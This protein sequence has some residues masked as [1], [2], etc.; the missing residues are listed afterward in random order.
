MK[1]EKVI[2]A[3]MRAQRA[4]EKYEADCEKAREQG[5]AS[6]NWN[7][8]DCDDAIDDAEKIFRQYILEMEK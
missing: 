1:F 3:I 6:W 7:G 8:R 2:L 5:D 4:I